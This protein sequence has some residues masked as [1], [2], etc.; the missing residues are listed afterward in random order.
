MTDHTI[1][2]RGK[3]RTR[4]VDAPRPITLRVAH[5]VLERLANDLLDLPAEQARRGRI[6]EGGAAFQIDAINAFTRRVQNELVAPIEM[7]QGGL[8]SQALGNFGMQVG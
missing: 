1:T 3:N 4:V 8:G 7:R 2:T 6:D 5:D